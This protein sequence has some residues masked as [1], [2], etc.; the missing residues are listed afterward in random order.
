MRRH[1]T[2]AAMTVLVG[3]VM[4]AMVPARAVANQ[5]ARQ[6][7]APS[8]S[9]DLRKIGIDLKAKMTEAQV[10][11]AL[12]AAGV[13][14]VEKKPSRSDPEMTFWSL[15]NGIDLGMKG[16]VLKQAARKTP[17]AN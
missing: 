1:I 3:L 8:L 17:P 11:A 12:D 6:I 10:Q 13:K 2:L 16:G 9:D 14:V 7:A 4:G 5:I 15:D